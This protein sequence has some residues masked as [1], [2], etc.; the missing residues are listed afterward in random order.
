MFETMDFVAKIH[1]LVRNDPTVMPAREVFRLATLGGATALGL[2][3]RIGSIEAGKLADLVIVE[4][5]PEQRPLYDVYS[6]LVYVTKGASVQ[7]TIVHG[8]VVMRDR[9]M[10]TVNE[11]DVMARTLS[12]QQQVLKTLGRPPAPATPTPPTRSQP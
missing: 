6:H 2:A 5:K 10:L 7:T 8:R 11:D 12:L 1:K 9:R 3:D 4:I